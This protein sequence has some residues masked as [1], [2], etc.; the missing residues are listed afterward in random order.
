MLRGKRNNV[1]KNNFNNSNNND[2]KLHIHHENGRNHKNRYF[3]KKI[4]FYL[5]I[6]IFILIIIFNYNIYRHD[7]TWPLIQNNDQLPTSL[8]LPCASENIIFNNPSFFFENSSV[9]CTS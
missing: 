3:E 9:T 2:I 7:T 1:K 5:F 8:P 6:L 4:F